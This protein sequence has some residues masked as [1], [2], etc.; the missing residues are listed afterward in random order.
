MLSNATTNA[1]KHVTSNVRILYPTIHKR[2]SL[3]IGLNDIVC[4]DVTNVL[5]CPT[6]KLLISSYRQLPQ[7]SLVFSIVTEAVGHRIILFLLLE[8]L[9]EQRKFF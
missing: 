9:P 7:D 4:Y 3:L 1:G 5:I 6:N 2:F 8:Q